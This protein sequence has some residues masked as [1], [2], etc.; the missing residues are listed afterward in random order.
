MAI[1]PIPTIGE[2]LQ[3][4]ESDEALQG[5]LASV[6][7]A[8]AVRE[9]VS[10]AGGLGGIAAMVYHADLGS[11]HLALA[12]LLIKAAAAECDGRPLG[13]IANALALF[14]IEAI[15]QEYEALTA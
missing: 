9:A 7:A 11:T 2:L 12:A 1:D 10:E 6:L 13:P 8:L 4:A 15:D 5:D 14:N 3:Q